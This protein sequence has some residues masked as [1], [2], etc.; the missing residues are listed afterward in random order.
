MAGKA[1]AALLAGL[2]AAALTATSAPALSKPEV[3]S[4]LELPEGFTPLAAS[5]DF[6]H[7]KPGDGFAFVQGLYTWTGA[8][9]G[10][11]VGHI[12]GSCQIVSVVSKTGRG[13]AHCVANA[14]LPAGQILFGGYQPFSAGP[15]RFTYPII[16]GTGHYANARGWFDIRDIGSSGKTADVFHLL[17]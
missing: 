14:F 7:L 8:K 10:A 9:R 6:N 13:K 15:G 16:G 1:F 2:I 11:R 4:I 12:D 3:L 5:L 17:R